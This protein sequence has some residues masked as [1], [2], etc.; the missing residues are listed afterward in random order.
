MTDKVSS[1]SSRYIQ[2]K[3]KSDAILAGDL[4]GD[5]PMLT[6]LENV[7]QWSN[8]NTTNETRMAI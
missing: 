8:N 2:S 7:R 4:F 6:S 5:V 1:S 3:A